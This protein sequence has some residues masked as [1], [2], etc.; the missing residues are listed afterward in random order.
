[1]ENVDPSENCNVF[2]LHHPAI[3][4]FWLTG[5]AVSTTSFL[6]QIGF[7]LFYRPCRKY[8][9]KTLCMLSFARTMNSIAELFVMKLIFKNVYHIIL[10]TYFY[11][12]FVLVC[13]MFV[14][15]KNLYDKVVAVFIVS[16]YSLT[17]VSIFI[18]TFSIVPALPCVLIGYMD[19][20]TFQIYYKAF[21][22]AKF[23]LLIINSYIFLRIFYVTFK[24]HGNLRTRSIT[25]IVKAAIVSFILLCMTSLQTFIVD[26]YALVGRP[27][28]LIPFTFCIINSFQTLA[29]TVIFA[30]LITSKRRKS[31]RVAASFIN[32]RHSSVAITCSQLPATTT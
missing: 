15:S 14:F 2:L 30:I 1:M 18:Y 9:E 5:I 21:A 20:K 31:S 6:C 22:C 3:T 26:I 32:T 29:M 11:W 7:L 23:L 17:K 25:H 12:D 10:M 19:L 4:S 8:D 28:C 13:W 24:N 16:Q 27:G